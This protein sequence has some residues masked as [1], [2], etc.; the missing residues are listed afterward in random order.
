MVLHVA[1]HGSEVSVNCAVSHL[2][3]STR[4]NRKID[5]MTFWFGVLDFSF[6]MDFLKNFTFAVRVRHTQHLYAQ[7]RILASG[8][9]HFEM[10]L[11]YW[12]YEAWQFHLFCTRKHLSSAQWC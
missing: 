8:C 10:T 11:W 12:R 4:G 6:D 5:R 9:Y 3:F 7:F 1:H 2:Y